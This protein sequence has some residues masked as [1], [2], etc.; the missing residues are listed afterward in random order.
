MI[1]SINLRLL[2]FDYFKLC[3]N[4]FL[5]LVFLGWNK[6][7]ILVKFWFFL[8]VLMK[9]FNEIIFVI[10]IYFWLYLYRNL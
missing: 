8:F 9:V 7:Y 5:Y 6:V 4:D 1:Y 2:I 10:S 3:K